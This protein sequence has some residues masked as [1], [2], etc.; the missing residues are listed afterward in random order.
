MLSIKFDMTPYEVTSVK[1]VVD[2]RVTPGINQ[3]DAIGI[4]DSHEEAA[5]GKV[6]VAKINFY[7]EVEKLSSKINSDYTEVHPLISPD[8]KTLYVNRKDFP[9]NL[10]DD[11]I[12]VATL[13]NGDWSELKNLGSPL[14]NK[15]HNFVNSVTPDGNTLLL[16]NEYY[17]D[18]SMY[19]EGFS[20]TQSGLNGW[21]FP[22]N[23]KVKNFYNKDRHVGFNLS[24]SG[25]A[26]I[27]AVRRTDTKGESDLYASFLEKDGTWTEP[28]NLGDSINSYGGEGTP[29][30][31]SDNETIYF[32]SD[33]W[34][35]FGSSD[36]FVSRRKDDTWKNWTTPLNIGPS[37]NTAAWEA[38]YTIP[39][40]GDYAYFVKNGDIYRIKLAEELKPKPVVLISGNVYNSKT[41]QPLASDIYY[42]VLPK[43]TEA[44]IAHSNPS[45]GS[46]QIVLPYGKNY[47]YAASAN[48][49]ISVNENIDL[50]NLTEYTEIKKDL[51]LVPIEVGQTVRI[52][53]IFF[54]FGKYNL[55]PES[56]PEL[57]RIVE[58][59]TNN[60]S[61][62]IEIAGHTDNVGS[63]SDNLILSGQRAKAV[64]EYLSTKG[65]NKSRLKSNGFGET[66][67]I[68]S[69]DTEEGKQ[70][71]RRVEFVILKK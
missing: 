26:L 5:V 10:N 29:F 34:N 57:N 67:A 71:N 63:D 50:T 68:G 4:S 66:K 18:P 56:F 36:I 52:N 39:A 32:S 28:L 53:N 13:L 20:T 19:G 22:V 58:F 3:I 47:G 65:V 42:E 1:I 43:G 51:Y 2:C 35:G 64:L 15:S 8:G 61:I 27:M 33:G 48:G 24:N 25:K 9:P 55:R 54:D 38:Y 6:E 7:S 69:N 21:N 59:L 16:G 31:A 11:E 44:G 49:Y 30:L 46:Y 23:G 40:S 12:W 62:E 70:L 45:N 14:N 37:V 60:P 41:K 17:Q